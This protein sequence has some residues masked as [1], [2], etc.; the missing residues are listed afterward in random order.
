MLA[1][2]LQ[3]HSV[4]TCG[5]N[6]PLFALIIFARETSQNPEQ[7]LRNHLNCVGDTAGLEQVW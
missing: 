1:S 2:A 5:G 7:F 4:N 6:V 3:L